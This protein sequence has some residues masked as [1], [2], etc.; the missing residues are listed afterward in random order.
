MSN[1]ETENDNSFI[2]RLLYE[3]RDVSRKHIDAYHKLANGS[4]D[5]YERFIE[6]SNVLAACQAAIQRR[7]QTVVDQFSN[8]EEITTMNMSDEDKMAWRVWTMEQTIKLYSKRPDLRIETMDTLARTADT[9]YNY[10]T[11][12]SEDVLEQKAP[13]PTV[14][15]DPV[16]L[17]P[18]QPVKYWGDNA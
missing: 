8:K 14:I 11:K 12:R 3:E 6:H 10:I 15:S 9:L 1:N 5:D 17:P 16:E 7:L 13:K 2:L 4:S 18:S